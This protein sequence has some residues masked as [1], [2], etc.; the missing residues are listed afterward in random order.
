MEEV[1]IRICLFLRNC[2]LFR[3]L[4]ER[5]PYSL[6][7]YRWRSHRRTV[8]RRSSEG[9]EGRAIAKDNGK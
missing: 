6:M 5:L 4:E 7:V 3:L 1:P 8:G 9:K 2:Q